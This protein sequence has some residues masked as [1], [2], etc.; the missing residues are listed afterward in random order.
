[1]DKQLGGVLMEWKKCNEEMPETLTLVDLTVEDIHN[2]RFMNTGYYF[3][4]MWNLVIDAH[5]Y[6]D[7]V[8]IAWRDR[9][10]YYRGEAYGDGA[11]A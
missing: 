11:I 1:L 5:H 9:G 10:D 4:G 3:E 8:V 2:E 6:K 7:C